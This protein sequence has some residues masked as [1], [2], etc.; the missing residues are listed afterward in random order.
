M[1]SRLPSLREL[2][3]RDAGLAIGVDER[4]DEVLR[5]GLGLRTGLG[6]QDGDGVS[7]R[8]DL[9]PFQLSNESVRMAV[10]AA[11]LFC[12]PRLGRRG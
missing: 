8:G 6:G 11:G 10:P 1:K 9:R 5:D 12:D 7:G 2:D 3:G 4:R